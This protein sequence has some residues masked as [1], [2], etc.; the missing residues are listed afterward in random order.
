MLLDERFASSDERCALLD[1]LRGW[2]R[3]LPDAE[4]QRAGCESGTGTAA[5][6]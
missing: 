3:A 6:R 4:V 1:R 2:R 5:G